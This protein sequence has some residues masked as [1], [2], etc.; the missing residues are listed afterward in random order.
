VT[1]SLFT[2]TMGIVGIQFLAACA[3]YDQKGKEGRREEKESDAAR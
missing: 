3:H 2:G 1:I